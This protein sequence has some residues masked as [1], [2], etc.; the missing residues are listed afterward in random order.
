MRFFII[1]TISFLTLNCNDN[2]TN[3]PGYT[4]PAE[5]EPQE[6]IWFS[7]KENGFLGGAPFYTTIVNAIE[8]IHYRTRVKLLYG[9]QQ[10]F[11]RQEMQ[12]RIWNVLS[13]RKIDTSRI[14][15]FYN[16]KAFGAIQDPGPVFLKSMDGGLAVADFKYL[17]PDSRSEAIDRN[18]ARE[19]NLPAIASTMVS[20]GGAWQTNG[21]G[22]MLAVRSVEFDRNKNM[23][24]QQIEDEYK[25]VLGVKKIIW[26]NE[27]LKEEEFGLLEDG[28][29]GIGT[30]G[31]IDEFCRFVNST[32]VLLTEIPAEDTINNKIMKSSYERMEEAFTIL[33]NSTTYEGEALKIIRLPA[34]PIITRILPTKDLN[35][36]ERSWFDNLASDSVEF[37]LTTGYMNFVIANDVVVTSKYWKEGAPI[38]LKQLDEKAK[39][40]LKSA[41]PSRKIVQIDCMPLHHDG[42]GLHC[43]SRNQP[44]AN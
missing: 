40:I 22:T 30:G 9:P 34:G 29:Y 21:R 8:A 4:I 35:K 26:L 2:L 31:H 43:H 33:S 12:K 25:R 16:E 11:N 28:K 38:Q 39:T 19:M 14:E 13:D 5:F 20:E 10:G 36:E 3:K 27:G 42:A 41:F 18:V 6:F 23:S 17:H 32:T 37:Y 1:I 44:F 7:W 15:L 24:Q